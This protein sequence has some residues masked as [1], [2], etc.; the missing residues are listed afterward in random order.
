VASEPGLTVVDA[1]VAV[2]WFV[3]EGEAAVQA[4]ADLMRAHGEGSASIVGP[5]LLAHEV[6]TVLRRRSCEVS[7]LLAAT[8]VFFD[9]A[10]PLYPPDRELMGAAVKLSVELG[11]STADATYAALALILGCDLVTADRRLAAA[12]EGT[13]TVRS[14]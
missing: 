13:V 14:L 11:L 4:A 6:V 9:F 2:K 7:D 8:D 3:S 1:S 5:A 10:I 12:L